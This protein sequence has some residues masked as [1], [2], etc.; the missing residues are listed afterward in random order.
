V[1]ASVLAHALLV[2]GYLALPARQPAQPV[3]IYAVRIVDAPAGVESPGGAQASAGSGPPGARSSAAL[4]APPQSLDAALSAT[5]APE[6]EREPAAALAPSDAREPAAF[7]SDAVAGQAT[8][9]AELPDP[10]PVPRLAAPATVAP[11]AA[12]PA[13][14]GQAPLPHT[15]PARGLDPSP[16]GAGAGS[17]AFIAPSSIPPAGNGPENRAT[18]ATGTATDTGAGTGT[19][20][21]A[22]AARLVTEL[23]L[24]P[25]FALM[26]PVALRYPEAARRL[27]RSGT[28]RLELEVAADGSV[29]GLVV[30][31]DVPG[32][33]FG[34]AAREAFARARFS[35]PTV[36]G[37]PVRVRWRK[38]LYFRP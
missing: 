37:E 30:H 29:S 1:L 4:P 6:P 26:T 35:P 28:V 7:V 14:A 20:T 13:A 18:G 2:G 21:S 23:A 32:W 22:S 25:G 38:T 3:R 17:A 24:D 16:Q 11:D 9:P 12:I 15:P 8:A 5:E 36:N 10:E 33:G 34:A 19:G 27:S 31:E